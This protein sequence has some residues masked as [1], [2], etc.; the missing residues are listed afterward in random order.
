MAADNY[1]DVVQVLAQQIIE[2]CMQTLRKNMQGMLAGVTIS[3]DQIEGEVTSVNTTNMTIDTDNIAGLQAYI[4]NAISGAAIDVT[5]LIAFDGDNQPHAIA[6]FDP[7][8][9]T[10]SFNDLLINSAQISDLTAQYADL[11]MAEIGKANIQTALV[12]V[13]KAKFAEI[14]NA[15]I[16]QAKI[17]TAQI[18]GL[19]AVS[20]EIA[21]A[22]VKNANIDFAQINTLGVDDVTIGKGLGGKLFI[23]DLAVADANMVNLTV[24]ELIVKDKKTGKFVSLYYDAEDGIVKGEEKTVSTDELDALAVTGDKI[25]NGTINGDTKIIESSITA[26]TLNVQDIFAENALVLKLI[27]Q[28]IN[29]DELFA[30]KAFIGKLQ[31]TDIS[32][33]TSLQLAIQNMF[34]RTMQEVSIRLSDDRIIST[35][36][37]SQEFSDMVNERTQTTVTAYYS[38]SDNGTM[39]PDDTAEWSTEIPEVGNGE[40]LWTKTVTEYANGAEPSIVYHVT[41]F[42]VR[43]ADGIVIKVTSDVGTTYR[44]GTGTMTLTADVYAGGRLLSWTETM[45]LGTIQWFRNGTRIPVSEQLNWHQI[46]V[47][48]DQGGTQAIY[49]ARLMG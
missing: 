47:S 33:N 45:A 24:G 41:M 10:L 4:S 40:Y 2:A 13:L 3:A 16:A 29:V 5:K 19:T 17:D 48:L 32:S 31:T 28:N 42:G 30:N 14:A 44:A 22:L 38:I 26:K 6:T 9:N 11:W 21:N 36:T 15:E 49:S 7:E 8:T 46:A 1:S 27:A 23:A 12:D 25:A 37:G 34:D 39:P 18:T 43:G 35:V 20:A